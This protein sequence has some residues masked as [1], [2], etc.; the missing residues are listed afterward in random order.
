MAYGLTN[1]V[2]DASS[3]QVCSKCVE[4]CKLAENAM[5]WN[6]AL[7]PLPPPFAWVVEFWVPFANDISQLC[8][9]DGE[10]DGIDPA[11]K[12]KYSQQLKQLSEMGVPDMAKCIAV[13]ESCKGEI[14]K[15][16]DILFS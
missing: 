8:F 16:M 15:A 14:E 12:K 3:M 7:S 13:L 2:I 11:F 4:G 1:L 6:I 9:Q 10:D 5:V